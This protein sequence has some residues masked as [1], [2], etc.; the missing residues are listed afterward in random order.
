MIR[1]AA[2]GD[3]AFIA[4]TW[5]KSVC[6]M[7]RVPGRTS[8]RFGRG[9]AIQRHIGSDLWQRTSALVDAVLDR[10][11]SRAVVLCHAVDRSRI[12]GWCLYVDGPAV[13]VVHY[14]YVRDHDDVGEKL[15][16]RGYA[17]EMLEHIGV[18]RQAPVVCTSVGPSSADMRARYPLSQHLPLDTF[19]NPGQRRA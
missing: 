11:D 9:H 5:T 19:L 15:R 4:S 17:A 13:P 3:Q 1:S 14:L 10:R 2:P 16:G 18:S 8:E 12:V 7:N 6:S